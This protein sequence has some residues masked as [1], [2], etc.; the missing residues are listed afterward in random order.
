MNCTIICTKKE[1]HMRHITY[2]EARQNLLATMIK[3]EEINAP[4]MITRKGRKA[5]VLMSIDEYESLQETSYLMRSPKNAIR[6]LESIKE[7]ENK[8][9]LEK[10]LI[11]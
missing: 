3:A 2:S 8:K 1:K 10:D 9:G 7:I 5:C 4:I 11:E 6:L